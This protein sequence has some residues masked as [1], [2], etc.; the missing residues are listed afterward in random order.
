MLS[1]TELMIAERLKEAQAT[2][3]VFKLPP[4]RSKAP[5][6]KPTTATRSSTLVNRKPNQKLLVN[7]E[8]VKRDTLSEGKIHSS[9]SV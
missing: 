8:V 4:N 7:T 3:N 2:L 1:K 5:L 6:L 9:T